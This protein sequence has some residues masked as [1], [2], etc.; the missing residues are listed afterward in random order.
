MMRSPAI[1]LMFAAALFAQAPASPYA[2]LKRVY[3]MVKDNLEKLAGQMPEEGYKF[4]PTPDMRSFAA[5]IA[6]IADTQALFCSGVQG[7]RPPATASSKTSKADLIAALK[8]SSSIC[9]AAFDWLTP[10]NAGLPGPGGPVRM[11]N[12]GTLVYI[13]GHSNEEYGYAAVYLRLKGIVPPSSAP[14]GR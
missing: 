4:S 2:D 8:N 11:T 6:H 9:D 1:V 7:I 14:Q 5:L 10:A 13:T 12:L 3:G